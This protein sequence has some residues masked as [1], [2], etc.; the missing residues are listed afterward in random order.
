MADVA[1]MMSQR[2]PSHEPRR[3]ELLRTYGR[4]LALTADG[5]PDERARALA[6]LSLDE[7]SLAALTLQADE[8]IGKAMASDDVA[9]LLAFNTAFEAARVLVEKARATTVIRLRVTLPQLCAA[10]SS[11]ADPLAPTD[12]LAS[13]MKRRYVSKPTLLAAPPPPARPLSSVSIAVRRAGDRDT[14]E[15]PAVAMRERVV[16]GFTLMQYA[17]LRADVIIA[18][19]GQRPAVFER[20]G[21]TEDRDARVAAAWNAEFNADRLL[22]QQ[23]LQLFNR[24]RREVLSLLPRTPRR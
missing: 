22:F 15:T 16:A 10:T 8:A 19:D 1:R 17:A 24:F 7:A 2:T 4:V 11:G 5:T 13:P 12:A 23:Y 18:P 21:L 9:S 3:E 20:Y 14:E 6:S